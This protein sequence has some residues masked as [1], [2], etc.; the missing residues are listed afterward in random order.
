MRGLFLEGW[1]PTSPSL[2]LTSRNVLRERIHESVHREP[3]IDPERVIRAFLILLARHLP[4]S[5]LE[6]AKAVTGDELRALW[7]G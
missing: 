7:P 6:D 5:E 4:Q 3:G 1:H 2:P